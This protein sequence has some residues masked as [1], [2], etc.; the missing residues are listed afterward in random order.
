M[1]DVKEQ[2]R[3]KDKAVLRCISNGDDDVQKI[4]SNTT[5]ENHHVNYSFEKLEDLALITVKKTEGYVERTINGQK[6]VFQAP[7]QANLTK[8]GQQALEHSEPEDLDEYENLSHNELVEKTY[9]LENR[10]EELEKKLE[11]FRD[12]VQELI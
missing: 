11:V 8:K 5:L 6:R 1:A 2:L 9:E 12:Q 10:I 3:E 4:T 7:K